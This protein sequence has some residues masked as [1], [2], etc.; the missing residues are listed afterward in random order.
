MMMDNGMMKEAKLKKLKDLKR[1]LQM[2][3]LEAVEPGDQ[4]SIASDMLETNG[5]EGGEY[6]EGVREG[7][8]LQGRR[9]E[10]VE[11]SDLEE[12]LLEQMIEDMRGE[13]KESGLKT[14]V[15]SPP[16]PSFSVSIMTGELKGKKGKRRKV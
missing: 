7:E 11:G 14:R 13:P 15:L 12:G 5:D 9:E 1:M 2:K 4:D 10:E 6:E 8:R 16:K 3:M